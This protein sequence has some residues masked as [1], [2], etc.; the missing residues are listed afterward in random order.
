[1]LTQMSCQEKKTVKNVEIEHSRLCIK[2]GQYSNT[3]CI[4][5]VPKFWQTKD[6]DYAQRS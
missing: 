1:M 3:I 2:F 4:N 6:D 5:S